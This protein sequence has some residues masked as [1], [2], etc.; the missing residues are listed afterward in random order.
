VQK[1]C[2]WGKKFS[3]EIDY[4]FTTA[5]KY[6]AEMLIFFSDNPVEILNEC[7]ARSNVK[8]I[9]IEKS[10]GET[11]GHIEQLNEIS[12]EAEIHILNC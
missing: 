1:K 8:Q 10:D 4:I 5:K 7:I 2:H 9:V 11:I 6:E 3:K 12:K